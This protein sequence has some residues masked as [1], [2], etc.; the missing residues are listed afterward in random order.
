LKKLLEKVQCKVIGLHTH[1]G[2]GIF[3]YKT[4]R[5]NALFLINLVAEFPTCKIINLGGGLGV[6]EKPGQADLDLIALD[7]ELSAVKK[8]KPALKLWLEPGR[9][10]VSAAG[11]LLAK[12]TQTKNKGETLYIGIDAGMNSLIRPALYG[13]YHNIVNLS[14][15][16]EPRNTVAHIVGPICESGD[17]LGFSRLMPQNTQEGDVILIANAG[18]YGHVMSSHYNLRNPAEEVS[19]QRAIYTN[20]SKQTV[21]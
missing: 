13:A 2:S 19:L 18:A 12:V 15:L 14:K 1:V 11:V 5:D 10:L 6:S 9:F 17:T 8:L 7:K 4:W 20:T 3:D 21:I 16:N